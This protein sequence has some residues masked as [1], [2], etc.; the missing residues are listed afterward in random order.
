MRIHRWNAPSL[1]TDA[2]TT[3]LLRI[4]AA[5]L[6]CQVSGCASGTIYNVGTT[7]GGSGG[8]GG[9]A[10][11]SDAPGSNIKK[12]GAPTD[13]YSGACDPFSNSGC[14]SNKKCTALQNSDRT[15]TLGCGDKNG[16]KGEG[17]TCTQTAPAGT[18]TGD[19]CDQGLACFAVGGSSTCHRICP[20]S[21]TANACPSSSVC[22]LV[23]TG[24]TGLAFCQPSC[25]PLEQTGCQSNE[26]CYT[27][28]IGAICLGTT[29]ATK[30]PGDACSQPNE[31][32][33]GST[34]VNGATSACASF[35]STAATGTPSCPSGK[36]C[37]PL[38][39]TPP[40]PN[41]GYCK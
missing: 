28:N 12:D 16:T 9:Q 37:T 27:I 26:A 32:E 41:A 20:T 7:D 4:L 23:V 34:C 3:R 33:G 5:A 22:S 8:T 30:K 2:N 1:K 38:P 29:N 6:V 21:G 15:L 24:L 13:S 19:D 40:E 25:K 18:Q 10:D 31:C 17:E 11:A 39:G 14:D 36:T 35:C